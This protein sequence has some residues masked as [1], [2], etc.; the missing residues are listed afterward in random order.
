MQ[1]IVIDNVELALKRLFNSAIATAFPS[2][3]A[4]THDA[5][6]SVSKKFGDY[7]CPSSMAITKTINSEDASKKLTAEEKG[8]Q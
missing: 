4:G 8:K 5:L 1:A 3:Q 6:V 2:L 7:Q